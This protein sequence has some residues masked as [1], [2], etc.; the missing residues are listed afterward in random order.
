MGGDGSGGVSSS[1]ASRGLRENREPRRGA[2][3]GLAWRVGGEECAGTGSREVRS[4]SGGGV[5]RV[6]A[7]SLV[8]T[9][10][11]A[12][13]PGASPATGEPG[14]ESVMG[15]LTVSADGEGVGGHSPVTWRMNKAIARKQYFDGVVNEN[16]MGSTCAASVVS[17]CDEQ[18]R[19]ER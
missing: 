15:M 16:K 7:P 17:I 5:E 14:G 4:D 10:D 1:A 3:L 6:D 19:Q 18:C 11:W 13:C 2:G 12:C 8:K 9:K